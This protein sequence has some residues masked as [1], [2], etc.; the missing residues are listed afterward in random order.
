MTTVSYHTFENHAALEDLYATLKFPQTIYR[1]LKDPNELSHAR[2]LEDSYYFIVNIPYHLHH[3][4]KVASGLMHVNAQGIQFVLPDEVN[5]E[6]IKK[7]LELETVYTVVASFLSYLFKQYELKLLDVKK[8]VKR[9]EEEMFSNIRKDNI[10]ELFECNQSLSDIRKGFQ[11]LDD[12]VL[13]IDAHK[14]ALIYAPE[15]EETY[16]D[17]QI[18]A[19][20]VE[21]M[22]KGTQD[23][24][25]AILTTTSS[26]Q[27]N[28]LNRTMK[29][30][31]AITL[32]LS[33]P[34]FI[35]SFYGMNIDL[36]FQDHPQSLLIVS[37]G[38]FVLTV[39]AVAILYKRDL[40]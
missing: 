35:T 20:Q 5:V 29:T 38:S 22:L 16:D 31:T 13:S 36:P 11:G 34:T 14:P 3:Q 28:R 40:L 15:V 30:L 2:H 26:L 24:V 8:V 27:D 25:S 33:I 9:C 37:V 19:R 7:S 1:S 10:R 4:I 18:E 6:H 21:R 39:V 32:V 12:I 17:I 23:T